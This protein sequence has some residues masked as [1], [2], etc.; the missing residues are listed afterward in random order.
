MFNNRIVVNSVRFILL[1]LAQVLIFNHMNFL[2]TI[3]PMVYILFLYWYPLRENISVFLVISFLLGFTIDLFSDTIAMHSAS[4]LTLAFS[5]PVL[6]RFCFGANF[7]FQGFTFKNTTRVQRL[8]F[9][10]LLIVFHHLI[11]FS[12][13]ILSFSHF[14]LILKKV[15]MTGIATFLICILLSSLF[16]KETE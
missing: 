11:F 12:L 3:N 10:G 7:D 5:R 1:V 13:E 2:G 6:M 16:A 15:I 8:T 9:L 14:L 4:I